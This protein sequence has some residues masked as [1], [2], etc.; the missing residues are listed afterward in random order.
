MKKKNLL[1]FSWLQTTFPFNARR[2]KLICSLPHTIHWADEHSLISVSS[3]HLSHRWRA[4]ANICWA[5]GKRQRLLRLYHEFDGG[6]KH[7]GSPYVYFVL[8]NRN[9]LILFHRGSATIPSEM[10]QLELTRRRACIVFMTTHTPS[11]ISD[12][13]LCKLAWWWR[14]SFSLAKLVALQLA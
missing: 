1:S 5:L 3:G 9:Y 12:Q 2:M 14:K 4:T 6:Y 7:S 8:L 10:S 11:W 13:G